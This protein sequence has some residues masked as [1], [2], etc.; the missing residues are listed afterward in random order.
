MLGDTDSNQGAVPYFFK[1][2]HHYLELIA[3]S[4]KFV[5]DLT[6]LSPIARIALLI[7]RG[8]LLMSLILRLSI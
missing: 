4:V 8:D 5:V 2:E 1:L 3:K 7:F 6:F